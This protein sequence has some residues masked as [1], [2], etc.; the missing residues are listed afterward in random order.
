L[1]REEWSVSTAMKL[2]FPPSIVSPEN[3]L[4]RAWLIL[5]EQHP[6]LGAVAVLTSAAETGE[7]MLSIS[8][9]D[10]DEW[11]ST[12]FFV[13]VVHLNANSLYPSFQPS[14]TATCHWLPASQELVIHSSHWRIDGIGMFMLADNFMTHL[15]S[16]LTK[17]LDAHTDNQIANNLLTPSFWDIVQAPTDEEST[18]ARLCNAVDAV[19]ATFLRGMPSIGLPTTPGSETATPGVPARATAM[20]NPTMTTAVVDA[21][22]QRGLSVNSAVHASLARVTARYP[23][24]PLAKSFTSFI[25][26]NLRPFT[27]AP[28]PTV[29]VGNMISGLPLC[30]DNIVPR[31]EGFLAKNWA[32]VAQDVNRE[33]S[34]DISRIFD[35][36]NSGPPISQVDMAGPI[37]QRITQLLTMPMPSGPPP[38]QPPAFTGL[39][40]TETHIQR[41]YA[42]GN[43][44]DKVEVQELWLGV[45]V[46]NRQL[47]CHS[48]TFHDKLTLAGSFNETFYKK[49][50]VQQILSDTLA[51]LL[52]GLE[53][54]VAA[55]L[56]IRIEP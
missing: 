7:R 8:P 14:P 54:E 41:A 32:D 15:V 25:P 30:V 46:L 48:W 42:F 51:E 27:P 5:R 56:A 35:P 17:G 6:S 31:G 50:F 16:V 44:E 38:L 24:H 55:S 13:E 3:Y 47:C 49:E 39:G 33:Y 36:G 12:T 11:L 1:N 26:I 28:G 29:I 22:R 9:V 45:E 10:A 34:K 40:V 2:S 4:R 20:L 18:P 52:Q 53:I 43:G 37:Q 21:C 23:Q 19:L